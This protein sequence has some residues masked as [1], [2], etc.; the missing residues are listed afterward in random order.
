MNIKIIKIYKES[1]HDVWE[2]RLEWV[3]V[4]Y[5]PLL[6]WALGLLFLAGVYATVGHSLELHEAM[7]G[8]VK[9][10]ELV[11]EEKFLIGFA[12][13]V[14]MIAYWV[15]TISLYINGFRYAFFREGEGHW[16]TLNLNKRFVKMILYGLLIGVLAGLYALI[17][18]GVIVGIFSLFE[19]GALAVTLA[20][21]LGIF[22]GL[23]GLYL[24]FRLTLLFF[25]VA[26]DRDE[27]LQT[28]WNLLK[29]NVL[30]IIGLTFLIGITMGL[31]GAA[32][33]ILLALFGMLLSLVSPL[34]GGVTAIFI[35]L[36]TILLWLLNWGVYSKSLALVYQ[37]FT[38]GKVF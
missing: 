10:L 36:F 23:L 29:G 18:G 6:I 11:G 25:F 21:I 24:L 30:R 38:E 20:V 19:G 2:H 7:M 17:T 34:L 16:W 15:A 5:A 13:I 12:N 14:Y 4:A 3:K 37:T 27:P 8:Q 32:G 26:V 31:I 33:F 22:S 1:F 35:F 28:S 9:S